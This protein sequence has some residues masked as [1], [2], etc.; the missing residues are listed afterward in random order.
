MYPFLQ[1]L[2]VTVGVLHCLSG[3]ARCMA[4]A[5]VA[6]S[7]PVALDATHFALVRG[8]RVTVYEIDPKHG[9]SLRAVNAALL[10]ENGVVIGQFRPDA[11]S[12]VGPSSLSAPKR[13]AQPPLP[14]P[15]LPRRPNA[16]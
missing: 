16:L 11:R 6:S 1:R 14:A 3:G 8:D 15:Q 12:S 5:D 4:D 10:D 13:P 2:S 7:A 9:Y